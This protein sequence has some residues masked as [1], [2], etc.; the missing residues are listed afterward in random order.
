MMKPSITEHELKL[1]IV[2]CLEE[3]HKTFD[4]LRECLYEL[5]IYVSD[6]DLRILVARMIR[7][8]IIEKTYSTEK[9][10]FVLRVRAPMT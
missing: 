6:L 9:K 7:E 10:K 8:G 3:N 5:R 2:R 4:E 1:R